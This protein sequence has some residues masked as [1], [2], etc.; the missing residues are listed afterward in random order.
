MTVE[1]TLLKRVLIVEKYF[2]TLSMQSP[3]GQKNLAV[4]MG[5]VYLR[6]SLIR[7]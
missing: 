5:W 3:T 1:D 4:L 7:R 6:G 2:G